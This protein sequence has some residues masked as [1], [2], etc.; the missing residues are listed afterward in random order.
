MLLGADTKKLHGRNGPALV[1]YICNL[2][3][4]EIDVLYF[5]NIFCG[6]YAF[7]VCQEMNGRKE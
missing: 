4:H 7:W 1:V 3:I 2:I 5:S 6:C